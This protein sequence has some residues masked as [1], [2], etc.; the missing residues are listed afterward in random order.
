MDALSQ[1][2][3]AALCFAGPLVWTAC[4]QP[5][6]VACGAPC[7]D[8]VY[9]GPATLLMGSPAGEGTSR[10]HPQHP[11]VVGGFWLDKTEV[12]NAQFT[13]FLRAQ[14]NVCHHEG[15]AYPCFECF[16]FSQQ[17]LGF[18]CEQPGFPLRQSCQD[19]PGGP[20]TASCGDHPVVLVTWAG[21]RSYC[22]ARGKRLPSE[23][24]WERAANGAGP[25][26]RFPWGDGCPTTFDHAGE[27]EG[28][29]E[30]P[31]GP[32]TARANCAETHCNDGFEKTAPVGTFG[33]GASPEG[34]LDLAGNVLERVE[35]CY[36]HSYAGS[37]PSD[38]AAW[39]HACDPSVKIARSSSHIDPGAALRS[40][41]RTDDIAIDAAD[42][43]VGFRC[44]RSE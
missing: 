17:D 8:M 39:L 34:V 31:W 42:P 10:E 19:R 38:G 28:C 25:W 3:V 1:R 41:A 26:R 18:D 7:S 36:H 33:G 15:V 5:A 44:A 30:G 40:R 35:D 23:A 12:T 37:P 22:A 27:L 14:G 43:D 4:G 29:A 6:E 11:V 13:E 9:L 2:C 21:A 16:E 24:E 20:F 32:A